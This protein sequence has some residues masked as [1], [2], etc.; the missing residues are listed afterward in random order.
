MNISTSTYSL[1][2]TDA[3]GCTAKDAVIV[4]LSQLSYA[5]L[6]KELDGGYF[7][8]T[9]ARNP[10]QAGKLHFKYE[11]EYLNNGNNLNCTVFKMDRTQIPVPGLAVVYKDNRYTLNLGTLGLTSSNAYYIL[12][13]IDKKSE[14][15]YLRFKY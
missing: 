1:T 2:V 10:N 6:K 5:V 12:E 8:L 14:K 13:V 9:V 11:E 3:M 4:Y 15:T 7:D